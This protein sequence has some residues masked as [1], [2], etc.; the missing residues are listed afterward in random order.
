MPCQ[1]LAEFE[2]HDDGR[3]ALYGVLQ[4]G[5]YEDLRARAARPP[6]VKTPG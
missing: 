3:Q 2:R 4:G 6:G 1:A 5:V